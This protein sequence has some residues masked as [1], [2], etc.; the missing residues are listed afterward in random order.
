V[1]SPH[2]LWCFPPSATFTSFPAPGC[3]AC[4][5]TPAF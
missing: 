2:L 1:G 3:W 4:A 5:T